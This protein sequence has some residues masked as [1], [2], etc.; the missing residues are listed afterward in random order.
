MRMNKIKP[1]IIYTIFA[2]LVFFGYSCS[3]KL[4]HFFPIEAPPKIVIPSEIDLTLISPPLAP[5]L[6]NNNIVL[7]KIESQYFKL[8]IKISE[9]NTE[10]FNFSNSQ[11]SESIIASIIE[12]NR[13][14]VTTDRLISK[15]NSVTNVEIPNDSISALS[16]GNDTLNPPKLNENIFEAVKENNAE[17]ILLINLSPNSKVAGK[18]GE[19]FLNYCVYSTKDSKDPKILAA[20]VRTIG[21][22]YND[23]TATY[24]IDT[25]DISLFAAE[26]KNKF[27]ET[28]IY[29]NAKII[30]R[31][32]NII[33]INIGNNFKILPGMLGYIV[34]VN[35][36]LNG[37]KTLSYRALFE[38]T[39]VFPESSNARLLG[40]SKM[41][42]VIIRTIKVGEPVIMK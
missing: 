23:K 25:N 26:L 42:D 17:G 24:V 33:G 35:N 36:G 11:I 38:V 31:N 10:N 20:G 27:P 7:E 39:E 4:I 34:R 8:F 32:G 5:F 9:K 19:L 21:Y 16:T 12:L 3:K 37:V 13:F 1:T 41:D 22:T 18:K 30:N 40:N 2:L 28:N 15:D 6:P 29:N 14:C